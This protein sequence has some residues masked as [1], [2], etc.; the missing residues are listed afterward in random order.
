MEM[1]NRK[2]QPSKLVSSPD[3]SKER[4][5]PTC[6]LNLTVFIICLML[7]FATFLFIFAKIYKSQIKSYVISKVD[8]RFG[9][10]E[11]LPHIYLGGIHAAK[12]K[13][14]LKLYGITHILTVAIDIDALYPDDFHY[15]LIKAHDYELQDLISYFNA[16]NDF[17]K[18][19]L[20]NNGVILIHCMAGVSR[21]T[22]VL[23]AY[24]LESQL[25]SVKNTLALIKQK[26]SFINPN[27]GFREQ[28]DLYEKVLR[29]QRE[30][31]SLEIIKNIIKKQ[32]FSYVY[33]RNK[34][35]LFLKN[36]NTIF[37]QVLAQMI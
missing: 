14:L 11:I 2:G 27:P 26:R 25:S 24:I 10:Q 36:I 6:P 1:R 12:N 9:A 20:K 5:K 16:A 15:M 22:T 8:I 34:K 28:L 21:S 29:E 23:S 33:H 3:T 19:A 7:F 31:K 4:K 17:I 18:T 30:V 35:S 13:E 37:G 32:K